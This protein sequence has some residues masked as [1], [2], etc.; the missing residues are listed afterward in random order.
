MNGQKGNPV[1]YNTNEPKPGDQRLV[2]LKVW[3][4]GTPFQGIVCG[5][6]SPGS[7]PFDS[8]SFEL[9][10]AELQLAE[11]KRIPENYEQNA[12]LFLKLAIALHN[13][14]TAREDDE[15]IP[16]RTST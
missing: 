3:A 4:K 5:T 10:D 11:W 6:P 15:R 8:F 14:T 1:N 16:E 2:T 12:A 9:A 13:E 7:Y